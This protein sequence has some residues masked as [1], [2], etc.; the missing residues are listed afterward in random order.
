MIEAGS[1]YCPSFKGEG[2]VMRVRESFR[3]KD[4]GH[5]LLQLGT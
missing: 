5:D 3:G 2:L 4:M 1:K